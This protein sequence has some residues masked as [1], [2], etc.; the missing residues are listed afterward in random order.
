[1]VFVVLGASVVMVLAV[2]AVYVGWQIVPRS[3]VGIDSPE[4]ARPR[5]EEL[6]DQLSVEFAGKPGAL[7]NNRLVFQQG[8]DVPD[9]E[10]LAEC[11]GPDG[12]GEYYNVRRKLDRAASEEDYEKAVEFMK[13]SSGWTVASSDAEPTNGRIATVFTHD[14]VGGIVV[15]F[16]RKA[17]PPEVTF[18]MT[19]HCFRE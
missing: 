3:S 9:P 15:A 4:A 10:E 14:E 13:S 2:I 6:Q 1:M 17:S 8:T 12:P 16:Q 19:S 5:F 18:W 7:V 11:N